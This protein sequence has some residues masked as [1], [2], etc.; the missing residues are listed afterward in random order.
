M[1]AAAHTARAGA[2]K[3][4]RHVAAVAALVL[5]AAVAALVLVAIL[6]GLAFARDRRVGEGPIAELHPT[7]TVASGPV[8]PG[9]WA[10]TTVHAP[11]LR[12]GAPAVLDSIRPATA[13][14]ATAFRAS[15]LHRV[16][17]SAAPGFLRGWPSVTRSFLRPVRGYVVAP[18]HELVIVV[19]I[20]SR[21]RGRWTVP[22]FT[23]RY[24]IG[25]RAYAATY[26]HGLDVRVGRC[27]VCASA[28]GLVGR[29]S[30]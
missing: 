24:H 6:I 1:L 10:I 19:G 26:D 11:A 2:G 21:T 13:A 25:P 16:P 20:A 12:G 29:L 9:Q 27:N 23:G 4:R 14:P 7:R 5:V 28:A 17:P 3:R 15:V 22:A 18:G 30:R 8:L